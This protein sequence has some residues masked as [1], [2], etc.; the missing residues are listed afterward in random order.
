MKVLV[1][2]LMALPGGGCYSVA[3]V[4]RT[5]GS[6]GPVDLV[7]YTGARLAGSFFE[8]KA[9]DQTPVVADLSLLFEDGE[10]LTFLQVGTLLPIG[11]ST[12]GVRPMVGWW[13]WTAAPDDEG[14][15]VGSLALTWAV[16]GTHVD[17]GPINALVF[18]VEAT[19][20]WMNDVAGESDAWVC[21]L[22]AGYALG[23]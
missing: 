15:V 10:R 22:T 17:M 8:G 18:Y 12:L 21:S 3:G 13:S 1:L 11:R 9:G 2:I 16:A 7:G 20:T 19:G 5:I 23:F 4:G 6:A 14:G